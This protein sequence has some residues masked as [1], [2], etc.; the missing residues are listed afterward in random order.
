MLK[1]EVGE[2]FFKV[3][4]LFVVVL[5][6]VLEE[7][8]IKL[9]MILVIIVLVSVFFFGVFD[10]IIV[11]VVILIIVEEFG[12][13]VGYIW[14]GL[15]YMFVSVVGVLMWGKIFDIWG[16]KFIMFIVVGIFWI[17]F[18]L[19]VFSKNI[20]MFIVV[21]VIQGIGGG[22]IIIFVNVC[23]SDLFFM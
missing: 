10:I 23:I 8:C 7:L 5:G 3:D 13:I 22:G 19:S 17:G 2:F 14:I 21:W 4:V 20:G 6:L 9:E 16:W 18:L 11:S 15:V 1:D 12:L